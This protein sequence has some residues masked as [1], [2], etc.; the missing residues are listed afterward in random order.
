MRDFD[1]LLLDW[2]LEHRT[3][4]A[5]ELTAIVEGGLRWAPLREVEDS[6]AADF[7]WQREP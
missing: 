2:L 5:A 7:V 3:P 1:R 4:S 6:A